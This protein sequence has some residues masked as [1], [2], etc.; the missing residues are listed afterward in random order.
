MDKFSQDVP[1]VAGLY[2]YRLTED[3][4]TYH[5]HVMARPWKWT[6]AQWRAHFSKISKKKPRLTLCANA[7]GSFKPVEQFSRWWS[8]DFLPEP[9]EIVK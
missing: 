3:S 5:C 1:K 6:D 7:D 2:W 8:I 4:R 9:K